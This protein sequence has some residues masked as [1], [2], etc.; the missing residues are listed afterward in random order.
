VKAKTIDS[1]ALAK[2]E[3]PLPRSGGRPIGVTKITKDLSDRIIQRLIEKKSRRIAAHI[4]GIGIT[5]FDRW[6]KFG[7]DPEKQVL[8]AYDNVM[9]MD[10]R[11]MVLKAEAQAESDLVDEWINPNTSDSRAYLRFMEYAARRWSDTYAKRIPKEIDSSDND[12][13]D[14]TKIVINIENPRQAPRLDKT[15]DEELVIE[16]EARE[17]L[18][19]AADSEGKETV[20]SAVQGDTGE[21]A[22]SKLS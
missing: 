16:G 21:S 22:S 1:K 15:N 20:A 14:I 9:W 7:I 18:N 19:D 8:I 2:I 12:A 6:M 10:W 5:T 11:M 3:R 13:P 4:N 17:I